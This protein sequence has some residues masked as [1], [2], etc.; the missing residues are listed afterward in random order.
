MGAGQAL[1]KSFVLESRG[2]STLKNGEPVYSFLTF[3]IQEEEKAFGSYILKILK[4]IGGVSS[5]WIRFSFPLSPFSKLSPPNESMGIVYPSSCF[6]AKV[7]RK[8]QR[9]LSGLL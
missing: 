6:M 1:G 4:N 8:S 3:S 9:H 2:S 7:S 5:D